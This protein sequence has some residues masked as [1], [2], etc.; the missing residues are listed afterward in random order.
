MM[1]I[2]SSPPLSQ[3]FLAEAGIVNY[4]H[5]D[6]T[7]SGHT[8]HSE[9][10]LSC[11]LLS[12]SFAQSAIFL[13]GGKTKDICPKALLLNSGDVIIMSGD[14]RL[15]YHGI[16]KVLA[17]AG[18]DEAIPACLLMETLAQNPLHDCV[19]VECKR[20]ECSFKEDPSHQQLMDSW[21]HFIP[22]LSLSRINVNV[23]QVV[24]ASCKF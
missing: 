8:D 6:S 7:L 23:R 9:K 10:D 13:V 12:I 15:A 5:L 11:P 16:P 22:Y 14:S 2:Y 20:H 1:L 21:T 19:C 17:P 4:Y 24:S 18:D 3:R